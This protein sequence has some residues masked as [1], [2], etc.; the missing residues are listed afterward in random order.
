MFKE[1]IKEEVWKKN[2]MEEEIQATTEN[3]TWEVNKPLANYKPPGLK[4]VY[5]VK[6]NSRGEISRYNARLVVKATHKD[7]TLIMLKF[8]PL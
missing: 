8:I 6:K 5:K 4:W 1:A 2:T 7:M 3:K